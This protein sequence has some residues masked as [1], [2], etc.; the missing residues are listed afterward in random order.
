MKL[1]RARQAQKSYNVDWSKMRDW[2]DTFVKRN[3]D[4][5]FDLEQDDEG[6][7]KRMFLCIGV[8]VLVA[9]LTGQCNGHWGIGANENT[10]VTRV[11]RY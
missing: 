11:Y 3:E 10:C 8:T 2:G 9:M 7:F 1:A 6:R 5:T 4:S